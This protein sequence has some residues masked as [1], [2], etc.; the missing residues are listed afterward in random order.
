MTETVTIQD[1]LQTLT[2][3]YEARR[4]ALERLQAEQATQAA[5]LAQLD[6]AQADRAAQAQARQAAQRAFN[7]AQAQ[8]QDQAQE[9]NEQAR[10]WQL[11]AANVVRALEALR[12]ERAAL[13]GRLV[14][15]GGALGQVYAAHKA[16]WESEQ[17]RVE[18]LEADVRRLVAGVDLHLGLP[19]KVRVELRYDALDLGA[20]GRAASAAKRQPIEAVNAALARE[21]AASG[22]RG[23]Q[24]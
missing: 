12:Q 14:A 3:D 22:A 18:A 5:A 17:E 7:Q 23:V 6:A 8:A 16:A 15:A 21:E 9:V 24:G 20:V 4:A 2:T 11:R 1:H 19:A 13:Y 10:N